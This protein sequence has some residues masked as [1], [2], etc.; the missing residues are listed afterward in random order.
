M[1]VVHQLL[2]DMLRMTNLATW[3]HEVDVESPH[4]DPVI[5]WNVYWD[6]PPR[7]PPLAHQEPSELNILLVAVILQE[8]V[9][10]RIPRYSLPE[11]PQVGD[12]WPDVVKT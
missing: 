9:P 3:Q 2:Q 11:K 1:Q 12:G 5:P 8:G 10:I 7:V 6:A 4:P